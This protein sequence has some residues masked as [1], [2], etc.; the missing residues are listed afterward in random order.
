MPQAAKLPYEHQISFSSSCRDLAGIKLTFYSRDINQNLHFVCYKVWGSRDSAVA[1]NVAWVRFWP[2]GWVCCRF[3]PC[4][5]GFSP[6]FPD[7]PPSTKTSTPNSNST[8]VEDQRE[9]DVASSFNTVRLTNK[10]SQGEF[11]PRWQTQNDE[12]NPFRAIFFKENVLVCKYI[13]SWI[14]SKEAW[15]L[16]GISQRV[17]SSYL[18][19]KSGSLDNV[20]IHQLISNAR[21]WDNC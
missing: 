15:T 17:F 13:C 19:L 12:G 2:L 1:T 10:L 4:S 11:W 16:H 14:N 5:E 21:S 3:L 8:R 9:A 20:F 18:L 6:G 7:L